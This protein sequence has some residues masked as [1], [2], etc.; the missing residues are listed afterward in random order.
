[1]R[2]MGIAPFVFGDYTRFI[3]FYIYSI[4]SNYPD[5]GIKIF[6]QGTLDRNEERC[7]QLLEQRF[8]G[9]FEIRTNYMR[10][11]VLPPGDPQTRTK[12]KKALRWL[13]PYKELKGFQNVYIG[14]VDFLI[15]KESPAMLEAHLHHCKTTGLPFS[16]AIRPGT[17]R[18]SGLHFF[19]VDEYFQKMTPVIDYYMENLNEVGDIVTR[20]KGNEEFLYH[21]IERGI[22]FKGIDKLRYR[23]HHGF[24]L[25]NVINRQIKAGYLGYGQPASSK[26]GKPSLD[27]IKPQLKAYYEDP[28]FLDMLELIPDEQLISLGG[29]LFGDKA[30][31]RLRK[32][33]AGLD[34]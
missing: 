14:D 26:P 1:M 28:L 3:P 25:G 7:L 8:P 20:G 2:A 24:H 18:L 22:G 12:I 9:S 16:N 31:K 13:I 5:Y 27:R 30:G 32:L 34:G 6:T 19:R 21:M 17:R 15:V 10:K 23:P 29:I 33:I 11:L 4:L